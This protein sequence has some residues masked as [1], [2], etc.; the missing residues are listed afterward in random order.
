[1]EDQQQ[2]LEQALPQAAA[3]DEHAAQEQPGEAAALS[4]EEQAAAEAAA[5]DQAAAEAAAAAAALPF[6][7]SALAAAQL[8]D[9]PQ[10]E[11]LE[12]YTA[13]APGQP[14]LM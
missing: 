13:V 9:I 8:A 1:M 4:A 14:N 6:D 3:P 12:A 5:A 2:H 7:F 10:L 11:G